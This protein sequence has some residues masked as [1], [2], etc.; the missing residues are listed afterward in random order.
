MKLLIFEDGF[1]TTNTQQ[2]FSHSLV[3]L[4]AYSSTFSQKMCFLLGTAWTLY[5]H[6]FT[7]YTYFEPK[8]FSHS[9]VTP[10]IVFVACNSFFCTYILVI[11]ISFLFIYVD[12]HPESAVFVVG[13]QETHVFICQ[14]IH[15]PTT[16]ERKSEEIEKVKKY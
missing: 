1:Q 16:K 5:T 6:I 10:I 2:Y 11:D 13:I 4:S 9:F 7:D 15:W 8:R 3:T 14:C 12:S